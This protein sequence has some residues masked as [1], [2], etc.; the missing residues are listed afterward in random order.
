MAGTSSKTRI[1]ALRLP[2]D[3]IAI[4]E[5]RLRNRSMTIS[6]YLRDRIIYDLTRKHS[7]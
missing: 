2:N 5:R 7:R 1:V 4:I 6:K 3:V